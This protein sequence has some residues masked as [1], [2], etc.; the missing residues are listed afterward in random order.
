MVWWNCSNNTQHTVNM[1]PAIIVIVCQPAASPCLQRVNPVFTVAITHETEDLKNGSHPY[2]LELKQQQRHVQVWL[3]NQCMLSDEFGIGI[4]ICQKCPYQCTTNCKL[5]PCYVVLTGMRTH[6]YG[7][8]A[9][10][11]ELVI[12]RRV[13][14]RDYSKRKGWIIYTRVQ[15]SHITSR[16]SC[17]WKLCS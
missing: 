2:P 12:S 5:Y 6:R 4:D 7:S 11:V 17:S 10:M 9:Y 8:D 15:N 3:V 14:W 13:T 16:T 1:A